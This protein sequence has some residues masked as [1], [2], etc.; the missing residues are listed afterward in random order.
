MRGQSPREENFGAFALENTDFQ[1]QNEHQFS[2][3]KHGESWNHE[4][5][6]ASSSTVCKSCYLIH[7][8]CA[9]CGRSLDVVD[10]LPA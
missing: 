4:E 10:E 8:K 9:C 6:H 7:S 2:T 3:Q 1:S 5:T